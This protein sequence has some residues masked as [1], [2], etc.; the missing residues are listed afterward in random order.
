MSLPKLPYAQ[1]PFL[2]PETQRQTRLLQSLLVGLI[3]VTT[4]LFLPALASTSPL[5]AY[6]LLL[7][8]LIVEICSWLLLRNRKHRASAWVLL[9]GLWGALVA[10]T[11]FAPA[12]GNLPFVGL[13]LISAAAGLVLSAPAAFFFAGISSLAGI[14]YVMADANQVLPAALLAL[15]PQGEFFVTIGICF[16]A[17]ALTAIVSLGQKEAVATVRAAVEAQAENA[18]EL[19]RIR[20]VLEKQVEERTK[21]LERRTRYLQ[22]AAEV[23]RA[24]SANLDPRNLMQVAVDL[25]MEKFDLYYTGV[26]LS[27]P[28]GEWALLQA[29]AGEAGKRMIARGHRI[30]VGSGMIGWSIANAQ[31]RIALDV[32]WDAVR[33][34]TAELPETRSEAAIPLRS[35]GK[36]LGA[37]TVQSDQPSAFGEVE[38]TIFQSLADQLAIA[39][40]NARLFS[41]SHQALEQ[42]QRAYRRASGRAWQEFLKSEGAQ[43]VEYRLGQINV[44]TAASSV[45]P[46]QL[47][48]ASHDA[49]RAGA[50]EK[51][52]MQAIQTCRPAICL[53]EG[54]QTLFLPVQSREQVVGVLRL[55]KAPG[56]TQTSWSDDEVELLS[57]I[58]AQLGAALDA[59]RLYQ[60]T[61]RAAAREQI[62]GEVTARIRQ[63]LDMQTV[64]RTAVEEIQRHLN[65][66]EVV[67]SLTASEEEEPARNPDVTD[68]LSAANELVPDNGSL[69][70][71]NT[72]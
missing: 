19:E 30:R 36:V 48:S 53:L 37:M 20:V 27:D 66:P 63:T 49:S 51:A 7:A 13:T 15:T 33:L 50:I 40:D 38:I 8:A 34:A 39:L 47:E 57:T 70:E 43:R 12:S 32:G 60:D 67:I 1:A 41:E 61:Q 29:G 10:A 59:A 65:L 4:L 22:A 44:E 2:N 71:E 16:A 3:V 35:R 21:D 62:T 31:P 46:A 56:E 58:G 45:S 11:F 26:F 14:A 17:A 52:R 23:S 68:L 18:R 64:L 42:S 25:I 9:S 69:P 6:G 72:P 24:A 28:S 5:A 55:T 54:L